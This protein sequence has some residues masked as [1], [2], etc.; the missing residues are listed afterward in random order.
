M[1]DNNGSHS[2]CNHKTTKMIF[3]SATITASVGV[4]QGLPTS[5]LLLNLLVNDMIRNLKEE[6]QPAGYL[7]WMHVLMLMDD[8]VLLA[9]SCK[10]TE[11]KI[12]VLIEFCTSSGMMINQ[13]KTQFMAINGAAEDRESLKDANLKNAI[14]EQCSRK[15]CHVIK[16][17]AFI[18]KSRNAPFKVKEKKCRSAN[19]PCAR[20]IR[21]LDQHDYDHE[22]Q[23][24]KE[25]A[26]TSTITKYRTYCNLMN[27]ELK[28]P[29]MYTDLNVKEYPRLTTTRFRL[30]SH[31]LAIE[32]GRWLRKRAEERVCSDIN[33]VAVL[34]VALQFCEDIVTR[35]ANFAPNPKTPTLRL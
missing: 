6:C 27:P 32:R 8:T 17:K 4:R 19:T 30:S 28:T 35:P 34:Q 10:Q 5:C 1:W 15:M 12:R 11:E 16:F 31:N 13:A 14:N 26:R 9:T 22:N 3:K 7:K 18:K 21:S 23:I 25:K 24:L 2:G 29:E 20:H 33:S